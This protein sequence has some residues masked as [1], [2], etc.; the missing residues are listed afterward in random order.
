MKNLEKLENLKLENKKLSEIVGGN[1]ARG[2]DVTVTAGGQTTIQDWPT[3][4]WCT[5]TEY[6]SDTRVSNGEYI[7]HNEKVLSQSPN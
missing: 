3:T 7:Y 4:G 1:P 5:T 2:G 6:S